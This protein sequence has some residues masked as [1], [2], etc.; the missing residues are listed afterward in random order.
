MWVED[1]KKR[2]HEWLEGV[3]GVSGKFLKF[4]KNLTF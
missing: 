3:L 1:K 2:P 4:P